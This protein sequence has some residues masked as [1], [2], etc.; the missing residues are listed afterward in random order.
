M[1]T[2]RE[3]L[4]MTP[5]QVFDSAIQAGLGRARKNEGLG[6]KEGA[7]ARWYTGRPQYRDPKVQELMDKGNME[8]SGEMFEKQRF[9]PGSVTLVEVTERGPGLRDIGPSIFKSQDP[10]K[11]K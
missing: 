11:F 6:I 10:A 7:V 1:T 8:A 2:R 4:Q 5:R 9:I 3:L